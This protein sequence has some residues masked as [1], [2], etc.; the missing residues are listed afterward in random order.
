MK[1]LL[2]VLGFL[3]LTVTAQAGV[4]I[5]KALDGSVAFCDANTKNP[6]DGKALRINL[7]NLKSDDSEAQGTLAVTM[8]KCV[9]G[10]WEN[11]ANPNTQK[12]TAPNGKKVT[13][14]LDNYELFMLNDQNQVVLNTSLDYL[15]KSVAKQTTE[16]KL[17][18]TKAAYQDFTIFVRFTKTVEAEG[19]K[20]TSW[21]TFGTFVVRL[22]NDQ[23]ETQ[24]P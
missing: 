16:I 21:A 6:Y 24:V 14:T 3:G 11:D 9:D 19:Y 22:T 20:E 12:Y 18:K 7:D 5:Q 15:N 2:I 10:K 17:Q 4:V 1:A 8:L 13:V 23:A